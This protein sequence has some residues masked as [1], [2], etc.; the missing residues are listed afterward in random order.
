MNELEAFCYSV[1]KQRDKSPYGSGCGFA[2][3]YVTL[4]VVLALRAAPEER[5]EFVGLGSN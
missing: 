5:M 3:L 4:Y 1:E 2:L